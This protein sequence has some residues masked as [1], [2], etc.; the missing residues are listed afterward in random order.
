MLCRAL[1][2]CFFEVLHSKH[3]GSGI[4]PGNPGSGRKSHSC[5]P[6]PAHRLK[7]ANL[8][9]PQLRS[10]ISVLISMSY[11]E[12][13]GEAE[14]LAYFVAILPETPSRFCT[15]AQETSTLKGLLKPA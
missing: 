11:A 9:T 2:M 14:S 13:C 10:Y 4:D 1:I 6:W 5:S 15:P 12:C 3:A 7:P 8:F